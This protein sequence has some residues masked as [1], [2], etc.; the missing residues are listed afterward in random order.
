MRVCDNCR[1]SDETAQ[2]TMVRIMAGLPNTQVAFDLAHGVDDEPEPTDARIREYC[3]TCQGALMVQDWSM[4][5]ARM[6]VPG[7]GAKIAKPPVKKRVPRI[8][9][10]VV[11][12]VDPPVAEEE[13]DEMPREGESTV[14]EYSGYRMMR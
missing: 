8:A 6:H 12:T 13:E 4:L 9:K 7:S 5:A 11:E 10:P 1:E 2:L 3:E 14:D